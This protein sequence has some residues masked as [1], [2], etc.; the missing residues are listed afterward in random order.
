MYLQVHAD[1]NHDQQK[2]SRTG[3]GQRVDQE[4]GPTRFG[5]RW[6][7]FQS[8]HLLELFKTVRIVGDFPGQTILLRLRGGKLERLCPRAS[9]LQTYGKGMAPDQGVSKCCMRYSPEGIVCPAGEVLH[10]E[11]L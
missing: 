8:V 4:I 7:F 3:R 2:H 6:I 9:G 1:K 5:E 10:P 11:T